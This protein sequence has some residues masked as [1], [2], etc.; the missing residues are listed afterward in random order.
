[1]H[2]QMWRRDMI[3]M[4]NQPASQRQTP[5]LINHRTWRRSW[6]PRQCWWSH[7]LP[8]LAKPMHPRHTAS[9]P[10][11]H[12]GGI[13]RATRNVLLACSQARGQRPQ[14]RCAG[15]IIGPIQCEQWTVLIW[16]HSNICVLSRQEH[17][18]YSVFA[19]TAVI[20]RSR[21]NW[22]SRNKTHTVIAQHFGGRFLHLL[23]AIDQTLN[24]FKLEDLGQLLKG[25]ELK[26]KGIKVGHNQ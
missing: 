3:G 18:F 2:S 11:L 25:L 17:G 13:T 8:L 4:N 22:S 5:F 15:L 26:W 9:S 19:C 24:R 16:L 23:I 12:V 20:D 6:G 21:S 7:L 10:Q 14:T 1:M